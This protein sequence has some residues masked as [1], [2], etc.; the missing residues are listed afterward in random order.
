[1][2]MG[3]IEGGVVGVLTK[4][5]F[6]GVVDASILDWAVATPVSYTHQTLP[7]PPNV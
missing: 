2:M 5:L 1:M 3:S 6:E 7:T 4:R